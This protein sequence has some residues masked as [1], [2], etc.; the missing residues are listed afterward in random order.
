MTNTLSPVKCIAFD[1]FGTIFDMKNVPKKEIK[2]YA[3][4]VRKENFDPFD[5]PKLWY[6]LPVFPDV[7]KGI[8]LLQ[9]QGFFCVTLSNGSKELLEHASANCGI[10]WNHIIDLS[11]H[12]VYKPKI[13]AYLSIEKDLGFKV[14]ETMMVTANVGSGD[15]KQAHEIGMNYQLIRHG[16]SDNIF[17]LAELLLNKIE[18]NTEKVN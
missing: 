10:K 13:E 4:H 8:N 18:M 15:L 9:K 6:H 7:T 1:C 3:S 16:Y 11:L 17:E 12:G 14:S 5:F 2:A